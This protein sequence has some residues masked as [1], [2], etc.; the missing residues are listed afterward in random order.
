MKLTVNDDKMEYL[1]VNRS[2]RNYG[3]EQHIESEQWFSTGVTY[4]I[5]IGDI[6]PVLG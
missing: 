5:E 2:N 1:I 6:D 4:H 3:L